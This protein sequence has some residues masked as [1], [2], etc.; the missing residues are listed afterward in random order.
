[1]RGREKKEG[2]GE[3]ERDRDSSTCSVMVQSKI[4][5]MYIRLLAPVTVV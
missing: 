1:M 4:F 5:H 3:R 2:R